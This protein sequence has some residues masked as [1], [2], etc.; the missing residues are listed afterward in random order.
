MVE[1]LNQ[2]PD[3]VRLVGQALTNIVINKEKIIECKCG[4]KEKAIF[5]C[6]EK[7]PEFDTYCTECTEQHD[8]KSLKI[9]YFIGLKHKMWYGLFENL[10]E[11][12]T[13]VELL[14]K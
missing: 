9:V 1:L 10:E 14:F 4:S 7:C 11:T 12:K 6:G 13:K 3:A 5:Y 2:V 8:H